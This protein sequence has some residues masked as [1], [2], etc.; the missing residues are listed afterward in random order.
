MIR[1][2]LAV[3]VL[4]LWPPVAL[5]GTSYEAQIGG[6]IYS[7]HC[8]HSLQVSL[9]VGVPLTRPQVKARNL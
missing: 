1:T 2:I 5:A 4:A 9:P 3:V 8:K 7:A 6:F